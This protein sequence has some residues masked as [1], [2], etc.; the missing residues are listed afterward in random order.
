MKLN[1][2]QSYQWLC[3]VLF[4]VLFASFS[5]SK[6]LISISV[7]GLLLIGI[8][9]RVK[10]EFLRE[11]N[12]INTYLPLVGLYL[13]LAISLIYSQNVELGI[14]ELWIQNGL[15]TVPVIA[16]LHWSV[17]W[18]RLHMFLSALIYSTTCASAITL[19]FFIIPADLAKQITQNLSFLQEY[20]DVINKTQF[21][22][23]SPFVD[24]LHFA[25]IIGF[26][27]LY[28]LYAYL[29]GGVRR[30]LY[31]SVLLLATIVLLG[32]RGAQLA[33]LFA[34]VPFLMHMLRNKFSP[35]GRYFGIQSLLVIAI[36]LVAF[37]YAI[38]KTVPAVQL[39]YDQMRW[40]LE[41]IA[42]DE[43]KDYD[44]KHFTTLT[45]LK[46][47]QNSWKVVADHP[48]AG[49]GIGDVKSELEV[50]YEHNS[51]DIPI[52]N[53][54][55]LLY[56]WMAGGVFALLALL[57]FMGLWLSQIWAHPNVLISTFGLSYGIFVFIVLIIDA[58]VKY[59]IGVFS[60]PLFMICISIM[61]SKK[62]STKSR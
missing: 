27:F 57:V 41:L 30:H 8:Y 22:L 17:L 5:F 29:N 10:G 46:S 33:L 49:V 3:S 39:R 36:F 48:I 25:Y 11:K 62:P 56:L 21:G 43:Y 7:V 55:Y 47:F 51:P 6:F 53:Q 40:E 9:P 16:L 13:V 18:S 20:P 61:A 26:S 24:R 2:R 14:R 34:L 59:H 32:A 19:F 50:V 31:L 1:L 45:R 35:K 54:N 38:Y 37:P 42:N 4:F 58:V 28:C 15:F 52:H 44:Y 12:I 23:Y 60:I